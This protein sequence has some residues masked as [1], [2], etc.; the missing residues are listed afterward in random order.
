MVM[1]AYIITTFLGVFGVSEKN[2]IIS[3]LQFPKD[4]EKIA[5]KLRLSENEIIE[6]EKK[7]QTELWKKKYREFVFSV[8]KHGVK[9]AEPGNKA[10]TFIK[11]NLR[12]IAIGKKFVKDQTE[13]NQ[14]LTKVN[15]EL[16]K[17]KIKKAIGRDRLIIQVNGAIEELNKTINIFI[18]RLRELYGLHFP[19]MDRILKNHE[20][21]AKIVKKYGSREKIEDIELKHF[22]G[23]SIGMDLKEEDIK[24]IQLFAEKILELYKLRE[25]LAKYL[26]KLVKD[27]APNFTELA[28]PMLAAKL[29]A[30]AGGLDKLAKA[31]SS[32]IQLLGSEK[33]LFRYLHGRGKSPKYGILFS[34]PLIQNSPQKHRGRIARTLASKLSIAAKMDFYSKEYKGDKL[35]KELEERVKEILSSK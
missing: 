27:I 5:E 16:T 17:V 34:H 25:S 9:H 2:K 33:A 28:G 22:A 12:K 15:L 32:T 18:E 31:A 11:E 14:L 21:F 1:R 7:V 19:E 29:I 26:E 3:F 6:E 24:S 30:K 23:K 13:F 10:E 4:P 35:K 8:R 20:K